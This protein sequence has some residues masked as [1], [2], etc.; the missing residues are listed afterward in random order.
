MG[1][2]A[3]RPGRRPTRALIVEDDESNRQALLRLLRMCGCEADAV[4]SVAQAEPR[5]QLDRLDLLVLDLHL[6]G[7]GSGLD[8]LDK[9]RAMRLPTR[10]AVT[11]GT[12]DAGELQRVRALGADAL[13]IKPF[14]FPAFM[15]WVEGTSAGPTGPA[16][17]AG[18]AGT[19]AGPTTCGT[20]AP[21]P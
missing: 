16:G 9:V 5:L 17:T 21:L 11:T 3:H 20:G 12:A 10:V 19:E 4:E 1:P 13:F 15:K 2:D 18:T 6:R 8:L 7:G 14:D